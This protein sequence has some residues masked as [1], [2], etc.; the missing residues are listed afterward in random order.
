MNPKHGATGK[1]T[2]VEE[3][4]ELSGTIKSSVPIVV[5][6]KIEGEVTGPEIQVSANGTVAGNVRVQRLHSEGEI[7]GTI[8]AEAVKISGRVR[9]KTVIRAKSLEV[10]VAS[11]GMEVVFGDCELQV[12]DEPDK[13][14]AIAAATSAA[15]VEPARPSDAPRRHRASEMWEDGAAKPEAADDEPKRKRG[16]QPPPAG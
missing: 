6:G 7:A 4:T 14:A 12:G 15:Q 9:N 1:H 3:G 5:M 11:Q 13:E 16:T 8:E 2:L 10:T